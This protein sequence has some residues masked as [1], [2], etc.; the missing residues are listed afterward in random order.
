MPRTIGIEEE[1]HLVDLT[2]RR[3]A[4]RAPELLKVLSDSYVA[5]MQS[6]VVETNGSVV[7]TL[8]TCALI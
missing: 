8:R 6:C 3:L 1:F 7:S 2:T 4:T 5:E